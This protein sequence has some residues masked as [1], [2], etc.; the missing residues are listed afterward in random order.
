MSA[1]KNQNFISLKEAAAILDYAPDYVGWLIRKRRISGRKILSK[2]IWKISRQTILNYASKNNQ[3]FFYEKKWLDFYTNRKL[4]SLKEAAE[5]SGYAP[6]Y[7]GWLIREKKVRGKRSYAETSWELSEK[8]VRKYKELRDKRK[9]ERKENLKLFLMKQTLKR[10][11]SFSWR[12][13]LATIIIIIFGTGP[14]KFLHNTIQ[15]VTDKTKITKLYVTSVQ[16]DWQ[17]VQNVIGPP[18]VDPNGNI[19]N[20]SGENSSVYR[21]GALTLVC[22]DFRPEEEKTS[23]KEELLLE[24]ETFEGDLFATST[25]D[26]IE[27]LDDLF[28]LSTDT[29]SVD[30]VLIDDVLFTDT[31]STD[32]LFKKGISDTKG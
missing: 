1:N 24:E 2:K 18:E 31:G 3:K 9:R 13:A 20:F 14:I 25:I 12:F 5:I 21:H 29:E 32:G 19:D 6:D 22:R 16:G 23:K 10:M 28:I 17:N 7:I 30:G 4:V 11:G 27:D 8:T 26:T 15:A